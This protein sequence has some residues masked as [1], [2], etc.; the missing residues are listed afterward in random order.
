MR[1]FFL[2]VA[3]A[4]TV[5]SSVVPSF[6]DRAGPNLCV[7]AQ[8]LNYSPIRLAQVDT[9]CKR[10]GGTVSAPVCGGTCTSGLCDILIDS[11]G[12]SSCGCA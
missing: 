7:K 11:D 2:V 10:M 8:A 1:Y 6:A 12:K 4:F 5:F 9:K 3:V